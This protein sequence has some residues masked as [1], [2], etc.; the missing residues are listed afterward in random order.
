[1]SP[2]CNSVV[3]LIFTTQL[4]AYFIEH[5]SLS[6]EIHEFEK[7]KIKKRGKKTF[8]HFQFFLFPLSITTLNR[9]KHW[10]EF[11]AVTSN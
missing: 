10:V 5:F 8:A 3:L 1:M 7:N 11:A 9:K 4:R 6:T 2:Q